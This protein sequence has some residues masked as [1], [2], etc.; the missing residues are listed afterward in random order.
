MHKTTRIG[1]YGL[2]VNEN[3]IVLIRKA[4]GA[5]RGKLDLPG[6]GIEFKESPFDTIKREIKEEVGIT[7][8]KANLIDILSY[9]IKWEYQ[10]YK[11]DLHHLGILY[12]IDFTNNSLKTTPDGRDSLGAS[13]YE[14]SKLTKEELSPFAIMGLE[15]IGY[16]IRRK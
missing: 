1:C 11:E 12:K 6:G 7:I 8:K 16:K 2:L 10:D 5:Y 3:R 9:N 15:K 4:K 14:I 13:F